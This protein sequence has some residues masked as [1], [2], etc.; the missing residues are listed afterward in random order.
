MADMVE[1]D[2]LE[3]DMARHAL[4]LP[5][6]ERTSYRNHFVTDREGA[7]GRVW[8]RMVEKGA[9]TVRKGSPLT[10]GDDLF[11]LTHAGAMAA[12][13]RPEKLCPEDFPQAPAR[14]TTATPAE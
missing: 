11:R 14:S 6:R 9:A 1:L 4:G 10:G 12:L 7:D 13:N 3:R 2:R 5:N 8:M